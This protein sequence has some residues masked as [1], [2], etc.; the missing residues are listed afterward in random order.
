MRLCHDL[1][2]L[3]TVR[4]LHITYTYQQ[5]KPQP[6][7]PILNIF[8]RKAKKL[9]RERAALLE[10]VQTYDYLKDEVGYRLS[11]RI[12]DIKKKFNKALNLGC[13]RGYVSKHVASDSV[14]ELILSDNS[15]L[16]LSQAKCDD[17]K[18]KIEK[19]VCDEEH[20]TEI[21]KPD[22]LDL[23]ISNLALH[24]VNELP[25]CFEQ[26]M[27]ILKSDGVF[28]ASV[29]GGDTLFELR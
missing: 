21:F 6:Q 23:V 2:R 28:L 26:V 25:I 1:K 11:D 8:D 20:L 12:F 15:E 3:S 5:Q 13:G 24:W 19:V 16:L 9:Q 18:V 10:N 29:F 7:Q 27:K 22:S 14:E 17:S 4:T